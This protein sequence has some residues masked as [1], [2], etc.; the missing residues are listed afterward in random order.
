MISFTNPQ[1]RPVHFN[2]SFEHIKKDFFKPLNEQN[3]KSV[4]DLKIDLNPRLLEKSNLQNTSPHNNNNVEVQKDS[5]DSNNNLNNQKNSHVKIYNL[6]EKINNLE[7][8]SSRIFSITEHDRDDSILFSQSKCTE[9]ETVKYKQSQNSECV[10]NDQDLKQ[11]NFFKKSNC[12]LTTNPRLVNI[13]VE[14]LYKK[15]EKKKAEHRKKYSYGNEKYVNPFNAFCFT[16]ID[17]GRTSLAHTYILVNSDNSFRT[18]LS[19]DI[20]NIHDDNCKNLM[21]IDGDKITDGEIEN[22]FKIKDE[23]LL[24]IPKNNDYDD[25]TK[26]FE[27]IT[28]HFTIKN[29]SNIF[30]NNTGKEERFQSLHIKKNINNDFQTKPA[31]S[32][33]TEKAAFHMYAEK[34]SLTKQAVLDFEQIMNKKI[35]ERVDLKNPYIGNIKQGRVLENSPKIFE[36]SQN[37]QKQLHTNYFTVP[38]ESKQATTYNDNGLESAYSRS[39][40][41]GDSYEIDISSR[42]NVG[43]DNLIKNEKDSGYYSNTH[44][45]NSL[46]EEIDNNPFEEKKCKSTGKNVRNDSRD[47][48]NTVIDLNDQLTPKMLSPTTTTFIDTYNKDLNTNKWDVKDVNR[49]LINLNTIQDMAILSDDIE[50]I[51]RNQKEFWYKTAS[52]FNQDSCKKNHM[53]TCKSADLLV[54]YNLF[55]KNS[56]VEFCDRLENG[57]KDDY[58]NSLYTKAS[59]NNYKYHNAINKKCS[60]NLSHDV[61][62]DQQESANSNK[63]N[64]STEMT[65]TKTNSLNMQIKLPHTNSFNQNS[66]SKSKE[67]DTKIPKKYNTY[68]DSFL[69][70]NDNYGRDFRMNDC[71]LKITKTYPYIKST[72]DLVEKFYDTILKNEKLEKQIESQESSFLEVLNYSSELRNDLDSLA[73]SKLSTC[74]SICLKTKYSQI[75]RLTAQLREERERCQTYQELV[76]SKDNAI[77]DIKQNYLEQL[78]DNKDKLTKNIDPNKQNLL[79]F[80]NNLLKEEITLSHRNKVKNLA[81]VMD[82]DINKVRN[83]LEVMNG[84]LDCISNNLARPYV[85]ISE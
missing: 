47:K 27:E 66:P 65:G 26:S 38:E 24:L 2:T 6:F 11:M 83:M 70:G 37:N 68:S 9:D 63:N 82:A 60:M 52:N 44:G 76:L 17:S 80:Q 16:D 12:G 61:S 20:H 39:Y 78:C 46:F 81:G 40:I 74:E 5:L 69:K 33:F 85:R 34:D 15:S 84:D 49:N 42:R 23:N 30:H 14:D 48:P 71:L 43:I 57:D 10:D 56:N 4:R 79:S 36:T 22:L 41:E 72:H 50:S 31:N 54:D 45:K 21:L 19:S 8:R 3:L 35:Q 64:L 77:N 75:E 28:K 29:E 51:K 67:S 25:L 32:R 73:D 53:E 58:R 55:S 1:L 62:G 18:W 7:T 59:N 13:D